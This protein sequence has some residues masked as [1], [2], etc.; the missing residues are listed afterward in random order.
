MEESKIFI[1]KDFCLGV[2][3][4]D[5]KSISWYGIL[6]LLWLYVNHHCGKKH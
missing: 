5:P 6:H 4:I 3:G 2:S 1:P